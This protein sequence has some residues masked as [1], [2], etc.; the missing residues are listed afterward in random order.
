VIG[1][2]ALVV[3]DCEPYGIYGGVPARFIRYRF[4]EEVIARLLELAWWDWPYEKIVSNRRF[5]DTDLTAYTGSL[6]ELI[7]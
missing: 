2:R 4:P 3:K 1:T 5:F 7:V 6:D